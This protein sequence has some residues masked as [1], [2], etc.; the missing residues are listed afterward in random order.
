M[1]LI[2][3]LLLALALSVDSLVV[4]TSCALQSHMPLRRG[5]LMSLIFALF[6]GLLP[7]LGALLGLAFKAPLQAVDHW[8]AFTLLLAVGGKMIW[9]ALRGA[10]DSK[11]LDVTHIPILCLLGLAT[12]I[13]AFVV[14]IGLGLD[15]TPTTILLTVA[16]ISAVTFA[17]ALL[18][19]L[20]GSRR[21]A[22]PE[23]AAAFLA[24]LVLVGLGT[25]T[26][27]QHLT[28]L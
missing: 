3:M 24:G 16:V 8:I 19:W 28:A 14:G 1:N 12:S 5:L 15:A 9:D 2:Q 22:L 6:Q 17:A 27:I 10:S 13:D 18:G 21:I 23:R 26:L 11:Q 20:L 4:A 7:Y 25:Y